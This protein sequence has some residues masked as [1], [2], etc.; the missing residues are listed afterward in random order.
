MCVVL[1]YAV[2]VIY[3]RSNRNKY[4]A[5]VGDES[6]FNFGG[7][8]QLGSPREQLLEIRGAL[9]RELSPFPSARVT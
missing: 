5:F 9:R 3:Y 2:S 1:S 4:R 8:P 6:T 7:N